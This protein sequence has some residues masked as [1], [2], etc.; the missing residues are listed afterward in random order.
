MRLPTLFSATRDGS[1]P[2]PARGL[3]PALALGL[4]LA[5]T[6]CGSDDGD[7]SASGDGPDAS[8]SAEP[9]DT[10]TLDPGDGTGTTGTDPGDEGSGGTGG[11]DGS[12]TGDGTGE[13]GGSDG[14]GGSGGPPATGLRGLLPAAGK[15]PGLNSQ[16]RWQEAGTSSLGPET[17][18]ECATFDL[19]S[20]GAERGVLRRYT[21][22]SSGE[23]KAQAVAVK[24][25]DAMTMQR[26]R[27]VLVAWHGK[28][29]DHLKQSK[30]VNAKVRPITAVPG[31]T[32]AKGSWYLVSWEKGSQGHFHAFGMAARGAR[33]VLLTM[34]IP[35]QDHNYPAGKEPMARAVQQVAS[36]LG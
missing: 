5:L 15:L 2:G 33:M 11:D 18:G 19:L 29:A 31:S 26:A 1:R 34:D 36:L 35:A 3:V 9:S 25:P 24:F 8:A 30:G 16:W 32:K 27:Q 4:A 10:P 23:T 14:S 22:A 7:D 20:I 12:G 17:I 13:D 6:G 21:G 28:C